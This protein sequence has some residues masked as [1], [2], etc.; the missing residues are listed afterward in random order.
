LNGRLSNG[1]GVIALTRLAQATVCYSSTHC[2][3]FPTRDGNQQLGI[4]LGHPTPLWFTPQIPEVP[5]IGTQTALGSHG[6]VATSH[7]I[8]SS[9]PQVASPALAGEQ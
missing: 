8:P 7:G 1:R 2:S 6:N 5:S 9:A 4:A 3:A